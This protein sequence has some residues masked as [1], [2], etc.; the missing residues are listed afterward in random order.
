MIHA[1]RGGVSLATRSSNEWAPVAPSRSS[2]WTDSE[3][4]SKTTRIRGRLAS[5]GGPGWPH[6]RPSPIMPSCITVSFRACGHSEAT[7]LARGSQAALIHLSVRAQ[8]PAETGGEYQ[9]RTAGGRAEM[10]Y[11]R[12][13]G[14]FVGHGGWGVLGW[15]IPLLL[16][17]ALVALVVYVVI[18][19]TSHHAPPPA[20]RWG[21]APP[22]GPGGPV[23]PGGPLP[24][25]GR[26]G[27]DPAVEQV[28]FRYSRG[29]MS[30]DE[31]F[32]LMSD[33]GYAGSAPAPGPS[34][35]PRPTAPPTAGAGA[36]APP[37]PPGAAPQPPVPPPVPA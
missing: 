34:W 23:G 32:R 31:Y 6:I 12:R 3:L 20:G 9:C 24:G 29:E 17:A 27:P 22:G 18:R 19:L 26:F 15:I 4:T 16:F 10:F 33:L 1:A 5:G 30:R 7:G 11:P 28:R 8:E 21:P 25:P 36:D 14:R 13:G 2:W 35:P 37:P